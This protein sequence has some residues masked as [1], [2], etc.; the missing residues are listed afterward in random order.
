M[1][2][3]IQKWGNSYA[4]RLPKD[5]LRQLNLQAGRQ[6]EIRK[7]AHGGAL[8]IVPVKKRDASLAETIARITKRNLHGAADWGGAV[9]K[10]IW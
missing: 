2:T 8:C 4:V 1:T 9:G 6:V 3:T 10:E 5:S 7:T